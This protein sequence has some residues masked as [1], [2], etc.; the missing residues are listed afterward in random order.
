MWACCLRHSVKERLTE[1]VTFEQKPEGKRE[2]ALK[3]SEEERS[4]QTGQVLRSRAELLG[5]SRNSK[6][7]SLVERGEKHVM[8]GQRDGGRVA[9][10][11]GFYRL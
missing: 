10:L 11:I 1:K 4:Q 7:V 2:F 9:N 3:V 5:Y 6:E 8:R